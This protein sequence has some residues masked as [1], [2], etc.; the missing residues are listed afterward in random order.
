[1]M[2]TMAIARQTVREAM[3]RRVMW[4]FLISGIFLIALGPVFSFLSPKD[5]QTVLKPRI[6]PPFCWPD[7]SSRSSPVST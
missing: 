7:C 5:S 4:V 3:R 6:W 2:V 1:M